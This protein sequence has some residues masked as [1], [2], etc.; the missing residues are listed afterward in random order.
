MKNQT[1][2][3][4]KMEEEDNVLNIVGKLIGGFGGAISGAVGG[5]LDGAIAGAIEG[6]TIVGDM[7]ALRGLKK[8]DT[9]KMIRQTSKWVATTFQDSRLFE[10]EHLEI[11]GIHVN[12]VLLVMVVVLVFS[13]FVAWKL[14]EKH[15]AEWYRVKLE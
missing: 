3:K 12:V 15:F 6:A 7:E 9:L 4:L 1:K 8:M 2:K 13:N 10:G 5:A 14:Y 11:D